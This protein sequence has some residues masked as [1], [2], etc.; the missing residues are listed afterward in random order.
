MKPERLQV[1]PGRP[2]MAP[3]RP[4]MEPRRPRVALWRPESQSGEG[5]K[6]GYARVNGPRLEMLR[7][8][9]QKLE[10]WA[11]QGALVR[12]KT[13]SSSPF[14][15]CIFVENK[16]PGTENKLPG[17]DFC[18]QPSRAR[19]QA[20]CATTDPVFKGIW[21]HLTMPGHVLGPLSS[22]SERRCAKS[23]YGQSAAQAAAGGRQVEQKGS[24]PVCRT[25]KA[26]SNLV[27]S[28]SATEG[29]V[30]QV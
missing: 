25:T 21:D 10:I 28:P 30:T 4:K 14:W 20:P 1:G 16:L 26:K 3:R 5:Q 24:V 29:E 22:R 2:K 15:A 18:A 8:T 9:L 27:T 7:N 17:A 6:A 11:P 19:Q 13:P 12:I 23:G